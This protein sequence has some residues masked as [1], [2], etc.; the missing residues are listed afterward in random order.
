MSMRRH[1]VLTLSL[2]LAACGA[3]PA[4]PPATAPGPGRA[5]PVARDDDRA[6]APAAPLTLDRDYPRVVARSIELYEQV[7]TSFATAGTDCAAAAAAVTQLAQTY[8]DVITANMTIVREDRVAALK[9]ALAPHEARFTTAAQRVIDSPTMS[10][11]AKE[12][13]FTAAFARLVG[14]PP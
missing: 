5:A 14:A 13:T 8:G 2:A 10:A 1:A 11:C 12:P 4:V 6:P 7:V 3:K 9:G